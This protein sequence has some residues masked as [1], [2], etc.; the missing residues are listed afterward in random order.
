MTLE[1]A[2]PDDVARVAG[3]AM[4]A[5]HEARVVADVSAAARRFRTDPSAWQW[6]GLLHRALQDHRQALVAFE[7]AAALAP[8]DARIAMGLAQVRLEAGFDAR[9]AFETAIRL[10][11]SGDALLGLMAAR[12]A[13]GDGEA[14]LQ[15]LAA[16][17]DR[18][19]TWVQ[20]HRQWAQ[21][22]AMIGQPA[23][24]FE[25]IDRALAAGRTSVSLWQAKIAMLEQAEQHQER[26]LVCD[27]AVVE[28]GDRAAFAL[29]RA[30]ALSD[31]GEHGQ[32]QQAF[33]RL[34]VPPTVGHAIYFARHL[35]RIGER[36][37]LMRLADEW[38]GSQ[39]SHHFWPYASIAWRWGDPDR[40]QWLEGDE[41]LVQEIDLS[42]SIDMKALVK[43]L[44]ALH[45]RSGRFL[46]QSV[47]GGTQTD[48]PLLSRLDREIVELRLALT[49]AIE[50][51]IRELPPIDSRH[52]MLSRRRDGSV[53]FAGSWSV[54]LAG[55]GFHTAH[56]HPQGWIS[57]AFYAALPECE[58]NEGWLT[59]GQPPDDLKTDLPSTREIC[60]SAGRLVLFPS[61]MWHGTRPFPQGE[62]MTVAFDVAGVPA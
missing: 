25:T 10:S 34:G 42:Q 33:A 26:W 41:R 61:M 17:I 49:D 18:N 37:G 45:A 20:G 13:Q 27:E 52:P 14:A 54:R 59:L 55:H 28:T 29:A 51:Y 31:D 40:W 56:V 22:A 3:E 5:G 50:R 19:P 38:M 8:T 12:Y 44:R 53:R 6:T 4:A 7:H 60:P 1:F 15:D 2:G 11:P 58:G 23:R 24:A 39:D 21:L 36:T 46:D 43:R 9:R 35:I 47:R 62:R 48:G 16:V 32:A 57:S 30:A